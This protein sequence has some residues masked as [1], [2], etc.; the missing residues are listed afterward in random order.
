MGMRRPEKALECDLCGCA[1]PLTFHHL[2]PRKV[3]RRAAFKK[4]YSKE[5]LNHGLHVGVLCHRGIHRLHDEMTLGKR[6][7]TRETLLQDE[8]VARHVYWSSKQKL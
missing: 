1:R 5:Q 8:A 3:H 4:N 2:I 7:N 6:L